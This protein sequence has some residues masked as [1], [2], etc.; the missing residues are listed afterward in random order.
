[1]L[2]Q[3]LSVT[4]RTISRW[5]KR[6]TQIPLFVEPA[7]REILRS[8]S[9]SPASL[10][11]LD[12]SFHRD[13]SGGHLEI[14]H[15]VSSWVRAQIDFA[16]QWFFSANALVVLKSDP[17]N[18]FRFSVR[19]MTS[20]SPCFSARCLPHL[21]LHVSLIACLAGFASGLWAQT[22]HFSGV[23]S[24]LETGYSPS[25][26]AVDSVGDVF[27]TDSSAGAVYKFVAINGRV[28]SSSTV[29]TVTGFSKTAGVAVDSN[30][31][32]FVGDSGNNAVKEIV[33]VSGQIS[34]RSRVVKVGSGF[35]A[36]SG[37]TVDPSGDVFVADTGN[38]A[39]KEVM[40][41]GGTVSSTSAVNTV[42]SGFSAPA[43]VAIDASGD[44][45]V[46]DTGNNAVDEIVAVNGQVTSG[47]AVAVIGSGFSAPSNV[48]VDGGGNVFVADQGNNAIKEIVAVSGQVSSASEVF[49]VGTGFSTPA[50][51]AVDINGNV[52]VADDGDNAVKEIFLGGV[53]SGSVAVNTGTPATM[54]FTFT[55]TSGGEIAVPQVLTQGANNLDFTDAGTGTCTSNGTSH[56]YSADDTCTVDV[57]FTP[58]ASGARLG[59]V[60]LLDQASPANALATAYLQGT[61]T[62]SQAL[63]VPAP[64][65][66]LTT[67]PDI[68]TPIVDANDNVFYVDQS[69][70]TVNEIIAAGG[71]K[72]INT[73]ATGIHPNALALDGAGNLF[74]A[75]NS[76]ENEV[77]ELV[78]ASGYQTMKALSIPVQSPSGLGVDGNGNLFF[79][80]TGEYCDTTSHPIKEILA[81]GD[82]TTVKTVSCQD[83]TS[84]TVDG[85][86]NIFIVGPSNRVE[87]IMAAGGYSTVKIFGIGFTPISGLAIDGNGN[88][89]VLELYEYGGN[90]YSIIEVLAAG[91][92]V[93][94]ITLP[95][96]LSIGSL[97][98]IQGFT[99]DEWGN[100]FLPIGNIY[101]GGYSELVGLDFKD[102]PSLEFPDTTVGSTSAGPYTTVFN[103]GNADLTFAVPASGRNPGISSGFTLDAATTCPKLNSS[104]TAGT[105]AVGASC[106]YAEDFSPTELGNYSGTLTLTDNS[107]NPSIEATQAI[108]LV[109]NAIEPH[110]GFTQPPPV[111][112][113][114]GHNPG[115][116]AVSV[117]DASNNVMTTSSATFTLTVTG[118]N[119]YSKVYTAK[120][121]SG[122]ATFNGLARL[123]TL[124]SYSYTATDIPDGLTQV[125]AIESVVAPHLAF[126][127]PPPAVLVTGQVP[128]TVLVSV[129][130][131]KN[132]FVTTPSA[133]VTLTVTG[134]NSYSNVYTAT[135]SSGVATFGSL[136]SFNTPGSYSY[137]ATDSPDGLTQA[138]A[139]ETVIAPHLAFTTPPAASL[140]AGKAP[141]IVVISVE[142]VHNSVET[143]SS[144]TVTLTV[145]GP[146]S[147]SKV[148]TATASSGVA[149]F[150]SLASFNT[151]GSYSYTATDIPDGLTQADA[152]E[153]VT[154]QP[155]LGNLA[156]AIDSVTFSTTVSQSDSV[157]ISGWV[158]DPEDG[159]PLSNVTV[160]IDGTSI[161]TPTLGIAFPSVAAARDNNSYLLS[162]Y[163]LLYP[164]SSLSVGTHNVTVI[165]TDSFGL[166]KTFGPRTFTVAAAAGAGSPFGSLGAAV[167][168]V[169]FST[170]V[171]QP[172]SVDIAGWVA[173]PQDGAPLSNVTVYIDG[174]SIGPPTLGIARS[175]VATVYHNAAYTDSGYRMSYSTSSLPLGAHNVTVIATDS[176]G[177]SKTF[178]PRAFTVAATAGAGSPFGSLGAAVDSVTLSTTVS[179]SDSVMIDG[180]VADP[181]DGAPL[182][183]VTIY[184][185]GISAGAPTLGIARKNVA[186]VY[187]NSAYTNSGF[188]MLYPAT[189]LSVG[190]HVVTVVAIDSGGRS[191]TL[192]PVE[193]TVQ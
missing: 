6:Q 153:T 14:I 168:S 4:T 186:A 89:Y 104:S 64:Q 99:V 152:T 15:S 121:S 154:A 156:S 180:W 48:G 112:L 42:G 158:A 182:G 144:A 18:L 88:L 84:L 145:T 157:E 86:G 2:A 110:L 20:C 65:K 188:K 165:A 85:K 1:V 32:V 119:S 100:L 146:N 178:G 162:G 189:S 151:P 108:Q 170:T 107:L 49:T 77:L 53:N 102:P 134:T 184:I 13:S 5:E 128:G 60:V 187:H 183:N 136:A 97:S 24:I 141:G 38:N 58:E 122:T 44:V 130:N 29:I 147:Y 51:A 114:T 73:L 132:Q 35:S 95:Q 37:V 11:F 149:T 177:R 91:G 94:T 63:F 34:P 40:A 105:L 28:S 46:A 30:G 66:A 41:V 36:P 137:T 193:F 96:V 72:T 7:L 138:V 124:G 52:V 54:T 98:S 81:A 3:K 75:D 113:M 166:S 159:A 192:N 160:Y 191:T 115:T 173:D 68:W 71:Y 25:A 103:H 163:K 106:V 83:I 140:G 9:E 176:G 31:N 190:T 62:G 61:G 92:Y 148:Y 59:A 118:P 55:F 150:G 43:G 123:S 12:L 161:G 21:R 67:G 27:I 139:T 79:F 82:Y 126:Y 129:E 111:N 10:T 101:D 22:V 57:S 142:D 155:P 181:T 109:G 135:A 70:G 56:T 120:A 164:A 45:F 125:V 169:T 26:I 19:P 39:V 185:D 175:D 74:L 23:V 69:T 93:K 33:A 87:E 8:G 50:A 174:L 143:T 17:L 117:E 171:G 16:F 47:S 179:Q 172:G 116:V 131:F 127:V 80:E 167:D 133:A 78:A 76:D 90:G